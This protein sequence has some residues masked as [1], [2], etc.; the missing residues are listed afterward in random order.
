MQNSIGIIKMLEEISYQLDSAINSML[1]SSYQSPVVE[2]SN[3]V[4]YLAIF[5]LACFVGCHVIWK[6]TPSLHAPLMSITN[7]ISSVIVLGAIISA[8]QSL[9]TT[10]MVFGFVAVFFAAVNIFGGFMITYRMLD[11][12]RSKTDK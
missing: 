9:F 6:V 4:L 1:I 8:G 7:A 11:M 12:F 10:S 3:F 2:T 5:L